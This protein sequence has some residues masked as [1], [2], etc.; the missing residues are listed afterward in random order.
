MH[1]RVT[2]RSSRSEV[3][4]YEGGVLSVRVTAPPVEGEANKAVI[5]LVSALLRIPKSRIEVKSGASE[6]RK[7][8]LIAGL[9]QQEIDEQL[10]GL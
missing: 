7:S 5:E 3:S 4:S 9:T 10:A 1:V 8:L 2:P 6:R